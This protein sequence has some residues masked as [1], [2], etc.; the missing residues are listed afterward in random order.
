MKASTHPFYLIL[1]L[2]VGLLCAKCD[3]DNCKGYYSYSFETNGLAIHPA[4][5]S[6]RLGDTIWVAYDE[7][8]K[9]VD[10]ISGDSI[11]MSGGS[12]F[13]DYISI[14]KFREDRKA[15]NALDLFKFGK[16][17]GIINRDKTFP[18]KNLQFKPEIVGKRL[19]AKIFLIPSIKGD[20][21][22]GSDN[23]RTGVFTNQKFAIALVSP[24]SALSIQQFK[25][26][27]LFPLPLP[28]LNAVQTDVETLIQD[29]GW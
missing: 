9:P 23:V 5:D 4:A 25:S 29:Y 6:I 26:N 21:L 8:L 12:N 7:P 3:K 17:Y 11:D 28:V 19:I 22:V 18:D 1:L 24:I 10:L 15:N 13:I 27:L 20:Y 2:F 16:I 14:I